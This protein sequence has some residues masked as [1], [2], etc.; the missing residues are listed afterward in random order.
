MDQTDIVEVFLDLYW[1]ASSPML[2]INSSRCFLS[3]KYLSLFGLRSDGQNCSSELCAAGIRCS[4]IHQMSVLG[5]LVE[6]ELFRPDQSAG[7]KQMHNTSNPN[8]FPTQHHSKGLVWISVHTT[9]KSTDNK[10]IFIREIFILFAMMQNF[11]QIH[12]PHANSSI[13]KIN[14]EE[15]IQLVHHS[16]A[17]V[18]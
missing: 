4:V 9:G 11:L 1:T 5:A 6:D 17:A 8:A 7:R 3:S 2:V 18:W 13:I 10:A 12:L 15:K 14:T 16:T